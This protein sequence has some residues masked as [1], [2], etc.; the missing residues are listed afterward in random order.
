V[1]SPLSVY[2]SDLFVVSDRLHPKNSLEWPENGWKSLEN[3]GIE[4]DYAKLL[5]DSI[6]TC[7]AWA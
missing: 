5:E 4:M 7:R 3:G 6:S 2:D 1:T